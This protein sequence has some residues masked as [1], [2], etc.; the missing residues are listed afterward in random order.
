MR[1]NESSAKRKSIALSALIK[2]KKKMVRSYI[3][4]L[5][6]YLKFLEQ[7]NILKHSQEEQT[8]GNNQ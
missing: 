4:N 7:K 1:H 2:K 8:S 3:S 6:A 5:A